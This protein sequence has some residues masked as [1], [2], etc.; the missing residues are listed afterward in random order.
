MDFS[1]AVTAFLPEKKSGPAGWLA[2][3][4]ILV[5]MVGGAVL[6]H[7]FTRSQ[8]AAALEAEPVPGRRTQRA[9]A[10]VDPGGA[11]VPRDRAEAVSP[12]RDQGDRTPERPAARE[13]ETDTLLDA[14]AVETPQ[15]SKAGRESGV[16]TA[17]AR[18]TRVS[19]AA[20]KRRQTVKGSNKSR[21]KH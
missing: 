20:H 2:V 9:A 12:P 19:K 4:L 1:G 15:G 10:G 13:A 21:G 8:V 7:R 16:A 17:T 5:A 11:A 14:P 18:P 6:A 3:M